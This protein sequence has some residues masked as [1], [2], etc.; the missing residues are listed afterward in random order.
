[1]S[2]V[3]LIEQRGAAA[4]LTLNRTEKRNALSGDLL[5]SIN[6]AVDFVDTEPAVRGAIL[7]G[8]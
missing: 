4:I 2:E 1:M 7:T 5:R 8:G 3:L 6:E